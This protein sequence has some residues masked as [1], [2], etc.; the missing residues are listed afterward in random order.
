MKT[1]FKINIKLNVWITGLCCL[2]LFLTYANDYPIY[3]NYLQKKIDRQIRKTFKI[4]SF[5]TSITPKNSNVQNFDHFM[6]Y[7]EMDSLIGQGIIQLNM[8]CKIDGCES[9]DAFDPN[10]MYD[11]FYSS[12]IYDL[13]GT[14]LNVKILEYSAEFGYE[15][16]AR[17]WLKQFVGLKG[18]ELKMGNEIDAISGATISVNALINAVNGQQSR[19]PRN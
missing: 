4:K 12:T 10:E 11:S 3:P 18:G 5:S 2:S 19:L 17:S 14:I 1:S 13:G 16:T 7:N 15:I 6:I 9:Q 8:G